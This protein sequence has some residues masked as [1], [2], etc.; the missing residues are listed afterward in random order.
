MGMRQRF[1]KEFKLEAVRLMKHSGRPAAA[2]A[3]ELGIPRKRLHKWVQQ[4][5][6]HGDAAFPGSARVAALGGQR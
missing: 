1:T 3:R 4:L 6:H 2:V 5:E